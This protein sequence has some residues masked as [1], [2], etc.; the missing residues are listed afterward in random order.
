MAQIMYSDCFDEGWAD[1]IM[2]EYLDKF[3]D[4]KNVDLT[5]SGFEPV[6]SMSAVA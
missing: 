4:N 1:S 3:T 2:L 5:A 6:M